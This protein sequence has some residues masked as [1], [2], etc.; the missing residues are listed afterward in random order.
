MWR[1][2]DVGCHFQTARCA[3]NTEDAMTKKPF[4]RSDTKT[5]KP[6]MQLEYKILCDRDDILVFATPERVRYVAL[7]HNAVYDSSTW[8]QSSQASLTAN[9]L[10]ISLRKCFMGFCRG[11]C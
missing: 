9:T 1:R 3:I 4:S 10:R 6:R 8:V 7:I 5:R 11:I 2:R